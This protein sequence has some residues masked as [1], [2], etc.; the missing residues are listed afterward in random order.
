MKIMTIAL[1]TA[2][3]ATAGAASA[4]QGGTQPAHHPRHET[5]AQLARQARVTEAAARATALALVPNGRVKSAELEREHGKLI[6]SFDIQVAGR[7]GID[8]VNVDALTGA[9]IAKQH[10]G[11]AE[12]RA[13]A[14]AERREK[15]AAPKRP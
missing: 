7:R 12:E 3:C 8:E 9:V 4:Q 5:Q 13:E 11:P 1:V 10:E 2:L 6:Y 14:R 15:A